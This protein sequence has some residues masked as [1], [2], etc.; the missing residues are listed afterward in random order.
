MDR[1][2]FEQTLKDYNEMLSALGSIA[3]EWGLAQAVERSFNPDW[4]KAKDLYRKW[5]LEYP[6]PNCTPYQVRI[7][8]DYPEGLVLSFEDVYGEYFDICLPY[9]A[10]GLSS[11]ELKDLAKRTM[12]SSIHLRL[13][14][15]E[16][17]E[18]EEEQAR[19][20]KEREEYL[21]LHAKFSRDLLDS[22]IN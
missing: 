19:L 17:R 22:E 5:E 13:K 15:K 18:L 14:S 11:D 2:Q 6:S 20:D 7:D 8:S 3:R 4:P 10:L 9:G 16:K 12:Q 21:R 1:N